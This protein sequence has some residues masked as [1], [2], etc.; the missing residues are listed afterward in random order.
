M[1]SANRWIVCGGDEEKDVRSVR[2]TKVR[3][4]R[5]WGGSAPSGVVQELG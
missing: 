2:W 5:S 3:I 1:S 4:E